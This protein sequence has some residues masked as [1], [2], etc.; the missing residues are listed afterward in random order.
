MR[1][2]R[3]LVG[4]AVAVCAAGGACAQEVTRA[5]GTGLGI[6]LVRQLAEQYRREHPGPAM[7]IP[8]ST[9]TSGAIKG[10]AVGRL[11]LGI[12]ARPLK[13]GEVEGGVSVPLC[14]TPLVFFTSAVRR[15]VSLTR[16]GLPALF[17]GSLPPFARGEV[18]MLLRPATDTE[19]IRLLEIFPEIAP[20][21]AAAREARGAVLALTD[22]ETMD[23]VETSRSLVAFGALT[24]ILAERRKLVV[25]P[26]DG[27]VP[28][29][30]A[31]ETGRWP[32]AVPLLLGLPAKPTDEAKAFVRWASSPSAAPLL[33]AAGCLPVPGDR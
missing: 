1:V 30:D 6:A 23:A 2:F 14:R 15:D 5:A 16:A 10:L 3:V 21:V 26:M 20:A 33:R 9:G 29:P 31:L 28:G 11:E 13:P 32:H 8:D 25:V 19:F 17:A 22:Q 12:L 24:P 27:L 7:V 4:L 18:R